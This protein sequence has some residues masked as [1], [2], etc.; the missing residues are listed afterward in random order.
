MTT[1]TAFVGD[2]HGS[3]RALTGLEAILRDYGEPHMVFLGDYINK[4]EQSAEVMQQLIEYSNDGRATLLRG[5]HET[6]LIDAIETNSLTAFLKMGGAMTIRS[7]V[8]GS[9]G[10]DVM[11]QFVDCIPIEHLEAIRSM[12][13]VYESDEVTARHNPRDAPTT[14]FRVSAHASVGPLPRI[15]PSTAEIDTDCGSEGGRLTAFLWPSRRFVQVDSSGSALR[16]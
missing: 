6:A 11:R 8:G 15:G 14:K 13:D 12:S 2:V 7:Y 5:N 1:E 3:F 4:G 10:P 16:L 9:V